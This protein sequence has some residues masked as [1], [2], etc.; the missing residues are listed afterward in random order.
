MAD[1]ISGK[2]NDNCNNPYAPYIPS[3]YSKLFAA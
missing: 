3:W 1:E 2:E